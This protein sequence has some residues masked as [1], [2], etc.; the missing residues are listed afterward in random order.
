[1]D[2]EARNG[3]KKVERIL[4]SERLMLFTALGVTISV[5]FGVATSVL[6]HF[7]LF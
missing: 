4:F 1:M 2:L 7:G 3:K 6:I 5:A